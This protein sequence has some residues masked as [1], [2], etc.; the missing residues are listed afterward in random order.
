MS[1]LGLDPR[2]PWSLAC[3]LPWYLTDY[4][5]LKAQA[6]H[7]QFN[8]P[9]G[10][11]FPCLQEKHDQSGS[12][13]SYY[14]YQDLHVARRIH[15][16]NPNRHVDIGSRID[17]FVANV[18]T[19]R[20]IEVFDIRPMDSPIPG[21]IFRQAD[22][23]NLDE[24]LIGCTD[25]LSCLHAIEHFGLGRYGDP[26]DFDGF[27]KGLE[28]M[29]KML[30]TGGRFHFSTPMGPQRI[31]FN[32]HRVFSARFLIDY[33]SKDYSI[34]SFSY[35]DGAPYVHENIPIDD[36]RVEGNFGCRYGCAILELIKK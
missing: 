16:L 2:K 31:E 33:F 30:A 25:S 24:S 20:E 7:S 17:G 15:Q 26:I 19:F 9:F 10:R 3:N 11:P 4:R 27:H 28:N 13:L 36:P 34:E 23:M 21:V 35:L 18:A 12:I 32:A 22:L 29:K 6:S 8:F 14:F 5:K 1:N